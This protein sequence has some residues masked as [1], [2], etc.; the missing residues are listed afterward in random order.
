MKEKIK[1]FLEANGI[2]CE[3]SREDELPDIELEVTTLTGY[4]LTYCHEI[5]SE[6]SNVNIL[7]TDEHHEDYYDGGYKH[8][9]KSEWHVIDLNKPVILAGHHYYIIEHIKTK[10]YFLEIYLYNGLNFYLCE[11]F[12]DTETELKEFCNKKLKEFLKSLYTES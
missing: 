2:D 10:N 9:E 7:F 5:G 12:F 1:Q 3:M 4:E 6:L 8:T 11:M